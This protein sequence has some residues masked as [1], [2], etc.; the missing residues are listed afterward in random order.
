MENHSKYENII[1][2]YKMCT[3]SK[4]Y[5]GA[6]NY[7]KKYKAEFP[8]IKWQQNWHRDILNT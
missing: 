5:N 4:L 7:A 2:V 8:A 6:Y 3:T 1:C